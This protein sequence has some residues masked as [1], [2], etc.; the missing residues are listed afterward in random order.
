VEAKLKKETGKYLGSVVQSISDAHI[1][2]TDKIKLSEIYK[3]LEI[4]ATFGSPYFREKALHIFKRTFFPDEVMRLFWQCRNFQDKLWLLELYFKRVQHNNYLDRV[5]ERL[6]YRHIPNSTVKEK[7]GILKTIMDTN[8][9]LIPKKYWNNLMLQLR[10]VDPQVVTLTDWEN[11][12]QRYSLKLQYVRYI[13]NWMIEKDYEN[14]FPFIENHY[15][16]FKSSFTGYVFDRLYE[17]N[18]KRT[19]S[20]LKR[21]FEIANERDQL[22]VAVFLYNK[23]HPRYS[24]FIVEFLEKAK[25]NTYKQNLLK[26]F[27]SLINEAVIKLVNS[28]KISR[29]RIKNL[30]DFSNLSLFYRLFRTNMHFWPEDTIHRVLTSK[31][32]KYY[33]DDVAYFFAVCERLPEPYRKKML[34]KIFKADI[35][36]SSR[37]RAEQLLAQHYPGEFLEIVFNTRYNWENYTKSRVEEAYQKFSFEALKDE[38][39]LTLRRKSYW[40]AGFICKALV[41]KKHE[42]LNIR[43]IQSILAEFD[44]PLERIVLRELRYYIHQRQFEDQNHRHFCLRRPETFLKKGF[45]TSKNFSLKLVSTIICYL[46]STYYLLPTNF[47]F[48]SLR[49]TSWLKRGDGFRWR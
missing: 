9:E 5:W 10:N 11:W 41:R 13:F 7:T 4:L 21:I 1:E 49:V 38:L 12:I 2:I 44:R 14:I 19:L 24:A 25:N 3:K 31:I 40:K 16:Y 42:E 17:F 37:Y 33:N 45:W 15:N 39:T 8:L 32:P 20:L 6:V 48:V 27:S 23:N 26:E 22:G 29:S 28:N 43:E 47:Y 46:S 18:K 30:L 35:D 36:E 34:V